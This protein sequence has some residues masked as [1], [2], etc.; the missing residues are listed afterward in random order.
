MSDIT[1]KHDITVGSQMY[2]TLVTTKVDKSING[3][4]WLMCAHL[5]QCHTCNLDKLADV[6]YVHNSENVI[7]SALYT[8]I[9]T[10]PAR[11]VLSEHH[12]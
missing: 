4:L 12:V 5:N 6:H 3:Y 2:M 11:V 8:L 7:G 9:P 1:A 10:D